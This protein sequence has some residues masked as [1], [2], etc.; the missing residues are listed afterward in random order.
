[1]KI[2]HKF[3]YLTFFILIFPAALSAAEYGF[4]LNQEIR[5]ERLTADSTL[6][7]IPSEEYYYSG[8]FSGWISGRI[9][10][11]TSLFIQGSY[12][13][14][15]ESF[16]NSNSAWKNAFELD[17]LEFSILPLDIFFANIGRVPFKDILGSVAD[18]N[19]DGANVVFYSGSHSFSG[20]AFYTGL[21]YKETAK[22]LMSDEDREDYSNSDYFAPKHY[23]FSVEYNYTHPKFDFGVNVLRQADIH[24]DVLMQSVYLLEKFSF[25]PLYNFNINLNTTAGMIVLLDGL[26][27]SVNPSLSMFYMTHGSFSGRVGFEAIWYSGNLSNKKEMS[28]ITRKQIGYIYNPELTNLLSLKAQYLASL[29]KSFSFETSLSIFL[30]TSPEI[31]PSYW[32]FSEFETTKKNNNYLLGEEFVFNVIYSPFSDMIFNIGTGL[33]FPDSGIANV[34][35]EL[36]PVKWDIRLGLL[37]SL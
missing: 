34:Y 22:I 15:N 31:I 10:E 12:D 28:V 7:K 29:T 24:K 2:Y 11:T 35:S 33:F 27:F 1:M 4:L 19:F 20:G 32:L 9:N 30:R 23:L 3:I 14:K 21:L 6:Y 36:T 26:Q 8:K 17:R 25:W 37:I 18:G 5:L 16:T 13:V